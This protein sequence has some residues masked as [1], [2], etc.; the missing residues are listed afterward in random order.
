MSTELP[1]GGERLQRRQVQEDLS[2]RDSGQRKYQST[3]LEVP[4]QAY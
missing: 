4:W 3:D 1:V 2:S